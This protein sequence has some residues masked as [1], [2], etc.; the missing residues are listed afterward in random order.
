VNGKKQR[1]DH[2]RPSARLLEGTLAE[3]AEI[4]FTEQD[5]GG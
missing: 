4:T 2:R 5:L 3:G 1:A